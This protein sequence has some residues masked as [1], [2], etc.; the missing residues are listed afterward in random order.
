LV[1]VVITITFVCSATSKVLDV[2]EKTFKQ[3]R[4]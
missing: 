1:I 3:L 2:I 4:S